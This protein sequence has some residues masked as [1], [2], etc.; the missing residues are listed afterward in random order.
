[1]IPNELDIERD[2]II[3]IIDIAINSVEKYP[4]T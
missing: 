4:P 2:L 3:K 1:M